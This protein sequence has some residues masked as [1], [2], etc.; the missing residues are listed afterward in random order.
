M[1]RTMPTF[2]DAFDVIRHASGEHAGATVAEFD[3]L[4]PFE[5]VVAVFLERGPAGARWRA[6]LEGLAEGDLL[7]PERMAQAEIPE[8]ADALR[9]VGI[10]ANARSIAPLKHLARFILDDVGAGIIPIDDLDKGEKPVALDVVRNALAGI[11]GFGPATAD[12]I[13][14]FALDRP[15]Y[16]VDRASFRV[17]VRHGWLDSTSSYDEAHDLLVNRAMDDVDD[18]EERAAVSLRELSHTLVQVGRQFCKAAAPRCDGCP[19][20]HLLPE[21]GPREADA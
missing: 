14:L 19:L 15:S 4:P 13:V 16:P 21:G 11:K 1:N 9:A 12:A 7:S 17:L 2:D 3:G 10:N 5:A 6:A 18:A 20:E 8:I